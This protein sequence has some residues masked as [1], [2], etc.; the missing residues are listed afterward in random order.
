MVS[1][2]ITYQLVKVKYNSMKKLRKRKQP[3]VI[4]QISVIELNLYKTS[5]SLYLV[6]ELDVVKTNSM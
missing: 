2:S 6:P 5:I 1:K 3:Y 4:I